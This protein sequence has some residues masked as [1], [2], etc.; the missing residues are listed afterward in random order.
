MALKEWLKVQG[1]Y[2]RYMPVVRNHKFRQTFIDYLGDTG[3][4]KNQNKSYYRIST[5]LEILSTCGLSINW[6]SKSITN[7]IKAVA[8]LRQFKDHSGEY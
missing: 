6:Y 7:M 1:T 8:E 4:Y 3:K 5:A 2:T